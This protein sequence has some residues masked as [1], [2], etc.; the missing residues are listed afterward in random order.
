MDNALQ[1]FHYQMAAQSRE[2]AQKAAANST[3]E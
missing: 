3:W 1:F 2:I